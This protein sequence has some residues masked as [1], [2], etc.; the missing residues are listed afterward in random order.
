M[1]LS[2]F[3]D[4]NG[5]LTARP[6]TKSIQSLERVIALSKPDSIIELFASM[7]AIGEQWDW[8]DYYNLHLI[9]VSDIEHYNENLPTLVNDDGVITESVPRQIPEMVEQPVLRSVDDV[10]APYYSARRKAKY[11]DLAEFADAFVK[12]YGGDSEMID[13]YVLDCKNVKESIPKL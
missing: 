13:K 5:E 3:K 1:D 12:H 6:E 10:L 2:Y 4:E 7:V 11:P 8:L 9:E